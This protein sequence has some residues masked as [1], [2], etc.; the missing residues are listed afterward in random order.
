MT[1]P[2]ARQAAGQG[3][4]RDRSINPWVTGGQAER[5][6]SRLRAIGTDCRLQIKSC[7]VVEGDGVNAAAIR[8]GH[9]SCAFISVVLEFWQQQ[10]SL[11]KLGDDFISVNTP[12]IT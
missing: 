4:R 2:L 11:M 3:G 5:G 6:Q 9:F 7:A 1:A 12:T 8:C 10:I